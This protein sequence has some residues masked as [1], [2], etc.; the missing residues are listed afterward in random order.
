MSML[1]IKHLFREM[2][3]K[4]KSLEMKATVLVREQIN[5]LTRLK[6]VSFEPKLS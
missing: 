3:E 2:F 4:E 5:Y 6:H 1:K